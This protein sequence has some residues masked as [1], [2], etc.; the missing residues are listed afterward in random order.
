MQFIRRGRASP[1]AGTH[2]TYRRLSLAARL[3]LC[4]GLFGI[5]LGFIA[6]LL[7]PGQQLGIDFASNELQRAR[8]LQA[9]VPVQADE[10]ATH[11]NSGGTPAPRARHVNAAAATN[12]ARRDTVRQSNPTAAACSAVT[13]PDRLA[14]APTDMHRLITRIG[15]GQS[16]AAAIAA[17]PDRSHRIPM[18]GRITALPR[19]VS[20]H[21]GQI[22]RDRSGAASA[23][24]VIQQRAAT[25]GIISSVQQSVT[26]FIAQAAALKRPFHRLRTCQRSKLGPPAAPAPRYGSQRHR[27][28]HPTES[29]ESAGQYLTARLRAA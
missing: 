19:V 24:P 18:D 13:T 26:D 5:P 9:I 1:Y 2:P 25:D 23:A 10:G 11:L 4:A 12:G 27:G 29:A 20:S 14:L 16:T 28:P 8:S 22:T 17:D 7:I 21:L 6:Y 3:G 15:V